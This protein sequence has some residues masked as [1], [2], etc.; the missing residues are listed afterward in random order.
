MFIN[1]LLPYCEYVAT[2]INTMLLGGL[3][4]SPNF[5][6]VGLRFILSSDF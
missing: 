4:G 3:G 1:V 5:C 2:I 6:F